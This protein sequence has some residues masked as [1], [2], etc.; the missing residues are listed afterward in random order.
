[1]ITLVHANGATLDEQEFVAAWVLLC[2][3]GLPGVA[4]LSA[5]LELRP[6]AQ[7]LAQQIEAGFALSVDVLCRRLA[8]PQYLNTMQAT[9][10]FR[11]ANPGLLE[12]VEDEEPYRAYLAQAV[13]QRW[14]ALTGAE[15]SHWLQR[16]TRIWT[17]A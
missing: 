14:L 15:R 12:V 5:S 6:R 7:T 3:E 10:E 16:A 1:M 9:R 17:A 8:P 2:A 11:E 13:R 4:P